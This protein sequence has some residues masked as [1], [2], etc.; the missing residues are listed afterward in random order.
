MGN[1]YSELK[2]RMDKTLNLAPS[3]QEELIR[4]CL[5]NLP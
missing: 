1:D 4:M 2:T 5:I 3:A